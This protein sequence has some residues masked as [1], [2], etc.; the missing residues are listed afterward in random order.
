MRI[1]ILLLL[2]QIVWVLPAQEVLN[3]NPPSLKWQKINTPNFRIIYPEGFEHQG[4]RMANTLEHIRKAESRTMGVSTRKISVI[5][6]NQSSISNGFVSLIPRRSEFYTMPPQDYNFT[7]TTEWLDQLAAHEFRHVAQFDRANTGFTKAL[8]YLFGPAT[9]AAMSVTAAPQ[10]FWEGDAVVAETAFTHGGRGRIPNFGLVFRTNFMEGRRF[11]YHKQY[12]R[13]YKD[14]IPNHYVFGYYMV[15][16]LRERTNDPMIWEKVAGRAWKVPFVPFTFSN[17]IKKETGVYVTQLYNEMATELSAKWKEQSEALQ[18]TE[19][20]TLPV[21]RTG[22]TDYS[23]PQMLADGTVVVLKGGI[24]D[25][26]QFR[27]LTETGEKKSF[28][29]GQVNESGMLSASGNLVV[30]NEFGFHPRWRMQTYSVIKLYDLKSKKLKVVTS[31]SR[32]AGAALSPD[33]TKIVTVES[34]TDYRTSLL[35]LD[36][37][38]IVLKKFPNPQQAF[39]SMPRWSDDGKK[40]VALKTVRSG[41]TVSMFDV[42][43]GSETELFPVTQENIGHPVLVGQYLFYNSPISGID[44]IYVFNLSTQ[45]KLQVT[46]SKYGAYNPTISPDGRFIYYNEQTR[47]GLDVVRTP[48]HPAT[49]RAI[50]PLVEPKSFYQVIT[51]QEGRPNLF[52]SIPQQSHTPKKYTKISGVFNPYSWGAYFDTGLTQADIG[53]ASQDILSTTVLKAGYLYDINERTGAWRAGVSYQNWFP[54]ID[55]DVTFANRSNNEG[56]LVFLAID[57]TKITPPIELDSSYFTRNVTFNWQERTIEAGLRIPLITTSSRYHGNITFANYVG[58]T[59]VNDF[60]NTINDIRYLS[61]VY[62][63]GP[64]TPLTPTYERVYPFRS[65]VGNGTLVSNRF[66]VSAYRLLKRSHR[67]INSKWGQTIYLNWYGTPYGG[68]YSGNQFSFYTTL[69]FPGLFKHHSLWGYWAYQSTDIP[70]IRANGEGLN[71]YT[72]RNQIPLPRGVRVFRYEKFYS[73][74]GNYTLPVWYPDIAL[75]P[76]VNIQR[77][78]ANGFVDYGF[79]SSP[80]YESQEVYLSMGAE[81]KLDLNVMRLLNQFNI[82]F[83]YSYGMLPYTVTRFEFLLG[84]INF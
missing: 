21:S 71:S 27:L 75:G 49:W 41:R 50:E 17:A 66:Q 51:E 64:Q 3:N 56:D 4:Q 44:N 70:R 9:Q 16:Y 82:G 39:Y 60:E 6:Q 1:I 42:D 57:S 35:V 61:Y 30:W 77:I 2:V 46:S 29:P 58:I 43:S 10:W 13:S 54:I 53:I 26:L 12:L 22:Y 19:F 15:S 5:L 59:K 37:A 62:R 32:F 20:Q 76:L 24:G 63:S 33:Q 74:A 79:G 25:F 31:K 14:N 18:V 65:Y 52:D 78:R 23:Y 69:F 34:S 67:D 48:F 45:Q 28:I 83:R 81:I 80:T 8:Y 40:I 36:T 38:G 84:T 47:D 55:V 72:F 73:M 11:N 7:G 68:D